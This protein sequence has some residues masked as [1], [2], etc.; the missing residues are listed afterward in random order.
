[1][2]PEKLYKKE[3]MKNDLEDYLNNI[4]I[5]YGNTQSVQDFLSEDD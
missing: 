5:D 1:M 4:I 3:L 2:F